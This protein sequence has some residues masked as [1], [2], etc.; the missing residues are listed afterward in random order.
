MAVMSFKD[1]ADDNGLRGVRHVFA[2]AQRCDDKRGAR[3]A[4]KIQNRLTFQP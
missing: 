1:T 3:V 2:H 4:N